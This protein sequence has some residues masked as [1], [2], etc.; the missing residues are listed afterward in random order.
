MVQTVFSTLFQVIVPISIPVIVG[1]LLRHFKN[2]DTKP[3]LI[4]YLY[5]LSPAII[6]ETL[7][8][9][10]L[11]FGDVY[12]TIAFALLNLVLL[13]AVANILGKVL[14]LPSPELAGLTLVSTFTNS[15]NYGLPLV[16]LAFGKLGL[17]KASVYIIAQMVIVHTLGVY[18]A[19]RSQFSAKNAI[20]SVFKLP[21][22]YAAILAAVLRMF[23][24]HL[25]AGVGK[26]V[27]MVAAAYSPVVLT[28]LGAQMVSVKRSELEREIRNVFWAGLSVRLFL[29][30][31][32]AC[33][34]L[35]ILNVKGVLY[36]VL[37]ILSS[38]P[39]A[40]NAVVLAEKFNAS[41]KFV[42]QCIL[43]TTLA[44]FFVLPVLIVIVR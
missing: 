23:D 8:T 27:S 43:W 19:A 6:L 5:F 22:I 12:K 2:L 1:G 9:A 33:L 17:D 32:V 42:S 7:T 13:W 16:L 25:P 20:K 29:S 41:P 44:S 14:K 15:V 39:A 10:D 4:L 30:P 35:Y 28:I 11:S 21:A 24:L 38:M 31:F 40:V 3:L 18:F 37:L 26:G 36:S 34:V